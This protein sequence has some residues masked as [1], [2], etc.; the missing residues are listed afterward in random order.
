MTIKKLTTHANVRCDY[1]GRPC[2]FI[3]DKH[4]VLITHPYYCCHDEHYGRCYEYTIFQK[5]THEKINVQI[6]SYDY[7]ASKTGDFTKSS[8]G[9]TEFISN[10]FTV[11]YDLVASGNELFHFIVKNNTILF[12]KMNTDKNND[13]IFKEYV[14]SLFEGHF[15]HNN[16]AYALFNINNNI[17]VMSISEDKVN[18]I[19]SAASAIKS[20]G[21]YEYITN[22]M[23]TLEQEKIKKNDFIYINGVYDINNKIIGHVVT[24]DFNCADNIITSIMDVYGNHERDKSLVEIIYDDVHY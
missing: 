15:V 4:I 19:G 8:I 24:Y 11:I 13:N 16:E 7:Y 2:A 6:A 17:Y 12:T 18:T 14:T 10:N 20:K 1:N 22:E 9:L 23:K 21:N 5:E 3:D